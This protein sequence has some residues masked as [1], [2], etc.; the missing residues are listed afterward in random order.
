MEMKEIYGNGAYRVMELSL[1]GGETMPRHFVASHAVII[2]EKGQ[3]QVTFL[4]RS[5]ALEPGDTLHIP[6]REP[7]SVTASTDFKA[8]VI[9]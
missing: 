5:T 7:H 9:F 6:L 4:D 1:A 2:T 8:L 3:A